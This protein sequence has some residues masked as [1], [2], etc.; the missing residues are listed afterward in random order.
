MWRI[1]AEVTLLVL[2]L[3]LGVNFWAVVKSPYHLRSLL[4]DRDELARLLSHMARE[5]LTTKA[6]NVE[7]VLGSF[8]KDITVWQKA[9]IQSLTRT[10]NLLVV[11]ASLALIPSYYLG[12]INVIAG[13]VLFVLPV[14]LPISALAKNNNMAHLYTVV[15]ILLKWHSTNADEC[16]R[17]CTDEEPSLKAIHEL[18]ANLA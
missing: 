8:S 9:H 5:G 15:P 11:M 16:L 1:L 12:N 2:L 3:V 18:I 6:S 10:R 4:K 17:Y 14:V 13:L 7:S